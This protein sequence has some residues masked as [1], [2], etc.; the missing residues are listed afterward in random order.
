MAAA[1]ATTELP[2]KRGARGRP[3]AFASLGLPDRPEKPPAA[4]PCGGNWPS[5]AGRRARNGDR[6]APK[7]LR[8]ARRCSTAG[9]GRNFQ[10][11]AKF[12]DEGL[13]I[14]CAGTGASL[15]RVARRACALS[16]PALACSRNLPTR[17][18][19]RSF[20]G[21]IQPR[22]HGA[23]RAPTTAP[24]DKGSAPCAEVRPRVG[25]SMGPISSLKA[26]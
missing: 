7:K 1:S 5:V 13:K 23:R 12:P 11:C 17:L 4:P 10:N 14:F 25:P 18:S 9:C 22:S 20:A 8:P 16:P 19:S 26:N 3:P 21:I 24:A 2:L 15:S 6:C